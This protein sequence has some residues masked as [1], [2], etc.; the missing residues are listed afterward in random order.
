MIILKRGK[1]FGLKKNIGINP[2]NKQQKSV[3][4]SSSFPSSE[5]QSLRTHEG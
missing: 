1:I 4:P 5:P 2:I 3:L